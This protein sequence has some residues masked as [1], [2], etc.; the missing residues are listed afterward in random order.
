MDK[1]ITRYAKGKFV[2]RITELDDDLKIKNE[3]IID[4]ELKNCTT[5]MIGSNQ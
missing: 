3:T 5:D 4:L 1:N 2:Q